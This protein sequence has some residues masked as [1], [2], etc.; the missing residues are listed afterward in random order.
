MR[1]IFGAVTVLIAFGMGGCAQGDHR[2][3][4]TMMEMRQERAVTQEW[5]ISCGAAALATVLRY[6]YG[7]PVTERKVALSLINRKE[8][9]EHPDIVRLREGFS[10]LDMKRVAESM[11]Y[12]AEGLGKM[13]MSDLK[14]RAPIIVPLSQGGYHHFVVFRG[15]RGNRV[16]LAD[17]SFGTRTVTTEQFLD[18]WQPLGPMGRI[19]FVVKGPEGTPNGPGQLAPRDEEFLTLG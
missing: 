18:L 6:Q 13:E 3:V 4:R 10:L 1:I 7:E 11:G 2:A 5:D 15:M 9:L 16:L 17:P 12:G 19:G 8:Y 14:E